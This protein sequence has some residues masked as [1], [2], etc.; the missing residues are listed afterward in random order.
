MILVFSCSV[1][2][3]MGSIW[4]IFWFISCNWWCGLGVLVVRVMMFCCGN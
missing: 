4:F 2:G 3:G 1:V